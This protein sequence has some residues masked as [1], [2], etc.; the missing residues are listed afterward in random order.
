MLRLVVQRRVCRDNK[1]PRN[2]NSG[3][4]A[5][6]Y[7]QKLKTRRPKFKTKFMENVQAT[8]IPKLGERAYAAAKAELAFRTPRRFAQRARGRQA[9]LECGASAPL[10]PLHAPFYPAALLRIRLSV[11][12]PHG[13]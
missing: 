2:V 4:V 9:A 6:L 10:F 7:R 12:L 5:S 8:K 3:P 13:R 1:N 11:A